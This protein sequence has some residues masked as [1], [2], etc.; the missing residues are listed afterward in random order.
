VCQNAALKTHELG[1]GNDVGRAGRPSICG[2]GK[3]AERP[4][5]KVHGLNKIRCAEIGFW[6][7]V[8]GHV[9]PQDSHREGRPGGKFLAHLPGQLWRAVFDPTLLETAFLKK[10]RIAAGQAARAGLWFSRTEQET[11]CR[12]SATAGVE[13][14]QNYGCK[15]HMIIT[16]I[17]IAVP[18]LPVLPTKVQRFSP[19]YC[20]G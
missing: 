11:R 17:G 2:P 1:F 18:V 15:V 3:D 19:R 10:A 8:S 5:C 6:H 20:S 13:I 4:W 14:R 12:V 9:K 16:L 7:T